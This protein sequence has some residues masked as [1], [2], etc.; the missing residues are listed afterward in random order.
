[1]LQQTWLLMSQTFVFKM[2]VPHTA[3]SSHPS[4]H[5]YADINSLDP[6]HH[7]KRRF[8]AQT[9]LKE[10]KIGLTFLFLICVVKLQDRRVERTQSPTHTLQVCRPR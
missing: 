10:N 5:C 1:M 7:I 4:R 2:S 8:T 6:E 3:S 9:T